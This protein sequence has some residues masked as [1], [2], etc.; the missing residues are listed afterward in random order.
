MEVIFVRHIFDKVLVFRIQLKNNNN[1]KIT[2]KW[3]KYFNQH[4][5][6]D[7]IWIENKHIQ[8]FS[9]LH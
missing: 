1:N 2:I 5:K 4:F 3:T 7:D 8:I 9:R 6:I